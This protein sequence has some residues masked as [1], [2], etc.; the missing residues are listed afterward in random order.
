MRILLL[1]TCMIALING[2]SKD[3]LAASG[4]Q[5][6]DTRFPGEFTGISSSGSTHVQVTYGGDL[7]V[8][9]KGSDNLIPHFKTSVSNGIL[10]LNYEDINVQDDDIEVY[11]TLPTI[12]YA[13]VSGS[14]RIDISGGFPSI[15]QFKLSISGSGD[16]FVKDEFE[17][18]DIQMDISG[19][20]KAD[21][22]KVNSN[23]AE[24][25]ISGSGNA[26]ITTQNTLKARI[27][28]SGIVYYNGNPQV[29]ANVSGSG[30]VVKL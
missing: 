10:H 6:T 4:N 25:N 23:N 15:N 11:V 20:G 28:G 21:L 16:I 24:V 22:L 14:G 12:N 7:K 2:C 19:S 17:V 18:E 5:V 27:S 30:K 3:R 29:D 13:T 8:V 26:S 9:L 1:F